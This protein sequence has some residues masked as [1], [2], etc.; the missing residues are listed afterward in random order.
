M[1]SSRVCPRVGRAL[2]RAVLAVS[3][4]TPACVVRIPAARAATNTHSAQDRTAQD[5]TILRKVSDYLNHLDTVTA[6]FLQVA[7]DGGVRT[8]TA[9]LQRP[10]KMRFQYDKPNPQ[11]LVAGFGLLVYHDPELDQTT[12]IPL[13]ST[14]LGIL[15]AEHVVLSGEGVTVTKISQPPGEVQ[16]SLIRTGKEAEGHLTLVFSTDPLELR[17]WQVTDSQGRT[18]DVSLYDLHRTKP[19]PDKYF[20]YIQTPS[21]SMAP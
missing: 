6:R 2:L 3:L 1:I 7:P 16:I 21:K 15:L 13:S 18:T 14:P 10:G 11:L 19:F 4:A 12:N 17:Q 5:Q 8:G 9:I 20:E